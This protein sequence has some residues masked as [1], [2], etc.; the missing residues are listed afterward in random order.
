MELIDIECNENASLQPAIG[1]RHV[2]SKK[3]SSPKHP[4]DKR[5]ITSHPGH[6]GSEMSETFL[7]CPFESCLTVISLQQFILNMARN[8]PNLA[9]FLLLTTIMLSHSAVRQRSCQ[10]T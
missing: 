6:P 2:Q 8:D 9:Q 5:G 1:N 3:N 4:A 10:L 7:D